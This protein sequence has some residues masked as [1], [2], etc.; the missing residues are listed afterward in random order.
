MADNYDDVVRQLL[1]GGLVLGR[2]G[3]RV[4]GRLVRCRVG[5]DKET[6]GWY[7]LHEVHTQD[8]R[9][10][11]VGSWGIWQGAEKNAQKIEIT[12]ESLDPEQA[13]AIRERLR[14]DRRR[15]DNYRKAEQAR[16]QRRA[17][18]V[19]RKCAASPCEGHDYSYLARKGIGAHGI[20]FTPGGALAVPAMDVEGRVHA[21]QFI[22]DRQA[23]KDKLTRTGTD[24]QFWPAGCSMAGRFHLVGSPTWLILLCEGYATQASLIAATGYPVA[25][26]FNANN[27]TAAAKVLAKRYP[28]ARILICADD[29]WATKG[30]PGITAAS[31]A[32]LAVGGAWVAPVFTVEEQ[33][34]LRARIATEI[35]WAA[36]DHKARVGDILRTG[37]G[38]LTDFN[39]LHVTE[40]LTLVRTQIEAKLDNL[41]WRPTG[42]SARPLAGGGGGGKAAPDFSFS[43]DTL[44]DHHTL[45]YGTETTFDRRRH[46]IIGL[47]ALRAAAGKSNVRAWLEH[48]DRKTC[49]P[50]GVGFDP[51]GDDPSV[52]CNL[53]SGWPTTPKAGSCDKLLDLLG[54]LCNGDPAQQPELYQWVIRWLAYPLQ[55]PGAKMQTAL[56][57]HGP[58][59]TGKNTF[60]GCIRQIYA[61][62][63][64][65]FS[66]VE[67]ESQFNGWASGKLFAIGNEVVSRAE[68][69]H[70]QGRLKSMVTETEQ[71]I[72]EKMLPARSEQNHCNFV[73]FSNRIDIAKLDH[74]DRR[75]C[76]IWTPPA[77]SADFYADV[78][79]EIKAGGVAALHHYLLH[80]DLGDFNE[81]S[82]PPMTR[83]KEDLEELGMDS[84]A[85]FHRDWL[86]GDLDLPSQACLSGDCYAAYKVW[87]QR[88]GIGKQAQKQTLLTYIG[89]QPAVRKAPERFTRPGTFTV[90]RQTVITHGASGPGNGQSRQ[91]WIGEHIQN[92]AD[93]LAKYRENGS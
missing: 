28:E 83:A 88:E 81:H 38:K 46:R 65:L 45:I 73:F 82:K 18:R 92:F 39:D 42:A 72:N 33:L 50:E 74:G 13:K 56:L 32:A 75:Y 61:Q 76:V 43:I 10:L 59:G 66:Q 63:A 6:R 64:C 48:P 20:R 89:K 9:S 34:A 3:L 60:F 69:Y 14:E 84:T 79:A 15:A 12:Q 47:S 80:L 53:W 52:E 87:C 35:D 67:L 86:R 58:E 8:N 4:T 5:K 24:K 31:T 21:V 93:A 27:L 1:A 70:I 36:E 78:A 11:I 51:A 90:E 62:Y 41:S 57:I 37:K 55:Q 23:H 54:Y 44:L 17:E 25:C 7:V 68:L 40:G 2:D 22:L 29:D 19:W 49:L 77:L 85:R 71:I 16:A 30:N 91:V 26:A